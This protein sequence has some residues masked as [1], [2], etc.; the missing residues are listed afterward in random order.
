[1]TSYCKVAYCRYPNTH[2]TKGHK[3]GNCSTYGHGDA[4]CRRQT[5]MRNLY[6]YLE[7]IL[8]PDKYCKVSD[9][10]YKHLHT[11]EAHHCP[12]CKKRDVHTLSEC[13]EYN[14]CEEYKEYNELNKIFNVNCPLCR[15]NNIIKNPKKIKG[16]SDKCSICIDNNV[17]IL[18][19]ECNHCCICSN[20]LLK[21]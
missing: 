13:K 9:C 1:M 6:S 11:S 14:E 16:L 20:C 2:V 19:T 12:L 5:S 21:L 10:K 18:F 15:T 4:E 7:E 17:E 3:C 8:P